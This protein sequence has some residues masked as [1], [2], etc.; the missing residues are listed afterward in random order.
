VTPSANLD[1]VRAIYADWE[2]GDFSR[3][4]WADPEIEYVIAD[5]PEPGRWVGRAAMAGAWANL[6]SVPEYVRAEAEEYRE[7]DDEHVLVLVRDRLRG[8][9][10]GIDVSR[11]WRAAN[12]FRI[13]EGKVTRLVVYIERDRAFAD[14]GLATEGENP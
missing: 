7:L 13:R 1:L 14:L 3:A 9:V 12:L 2:R 5:G 4:D 10:S 6:V 11:F 8:K